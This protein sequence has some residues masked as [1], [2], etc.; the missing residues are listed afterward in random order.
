VSAEH[1]CQACDSVEGQ[2]VS[3][4]VVF[5]WFNVTT[6]ALDAWRKA[7]RNYLDQ[8]SRWRGYPDRERS[9]RGDLKG[10]RDVYRHQVLSWY[11]Q[12]LLPMQIGDVVPDEVATLLAE[13]WN[14]ATR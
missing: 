2:A 11:R 13:E 1:K 4:P 6:R 12:L 8:M 5:S 14:E 10:A 7:Q 9:I 3:G